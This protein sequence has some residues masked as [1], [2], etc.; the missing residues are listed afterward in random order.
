MLTNR[1]IIKIDDREFDSHSGAAKHVVDSK[2]VN[3]WRFL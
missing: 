3:G 1:E 2:S